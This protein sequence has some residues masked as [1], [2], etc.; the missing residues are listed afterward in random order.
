MLFYF[1]PRE[2]ILTKVRGAF[3]FSLSEESH[4]N[5][6]NLA[7]LRLRPSE[8]NEG[9][10]LKIEY[11]KLIIIFQSFLRQCLHYFQCTGTLTHKHTH[12]GFYFLL[13]VICDL[14][15][16]WII[17]VLVCFAVCYL[18]FQQFF[19]SIEWLLIFIW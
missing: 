8:K 12:I 6:F 17:F 3:V 13:P 16:F 19:L 7:I 18:V 10:I 9:H 1:F 15:D 4:V 5:G 2:S 14:K 11:F